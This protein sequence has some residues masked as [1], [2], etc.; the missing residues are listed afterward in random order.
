MHRTAAFLL[1]FVFFLDAGVFCA[2]P[3]AATFVFSNIWGEIR[4]CLNRAV[5]R[6]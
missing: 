3:N 5:S 6:S 2:A 4:R 1:A